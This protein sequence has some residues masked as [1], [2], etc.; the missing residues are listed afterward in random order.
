VLAL[1]LVTYVVS[2]S[3]NEAQAGSIVLT[4]QVATVWLTLRTS[5][6]HR[7]TRLIASVLLCMAAAAVVTSLFAHQ[8]GSELGAVFGVCCLL[9]LIAPFSIVRHLLLRRDVDFETL[10]GAI[11]AY[12]LMGMF[13]A[14]AYEVTGQLQAA[15]FYGAAGHG[16]LSQNLFFSFVTMTTV[17]YGN[18]VPAGNPGQMLAVIEAVTGQLFLVVAVG[19]VISSMQPRRRERDRSG[20]A[21]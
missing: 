1:V 4:V 16:S 7:V 18:L 2:V 20:S 6:A 21:P 3:V 14:F 10:L 11:A 15:P 8:R 5:H 17:G 13:F 9:Y 12:L 19:K